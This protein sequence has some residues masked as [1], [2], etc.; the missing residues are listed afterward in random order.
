G[1]GPGPSRSRALEVARVSYRRE[2]QEVALRLVRD[3]SFPTDNYRRRRRSAGKRGALQRQKRPDRAGGGAAAIAGNG[4]VPTALD[5]ARESV[6]DTEASVVGECSVR[7][8]CRARSVVA[9]G[10]EAVAT[11]VLRPRA[12]FQNQRVGAGGSESSH[13]SSADVVVRG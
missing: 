10:E 4:V 9:T 7:V 12:E 13:P 6:L 3:L 1:E 2:A 5:Y 8:A 11:S